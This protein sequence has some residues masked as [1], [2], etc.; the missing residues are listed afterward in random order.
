MQLYWLQMGWSPLV[1]GGK[2]GKGRNGWDGLGV[3]EGWGLWSGQGNTADPSFSTGAGEESPLCAAVWMASRSSTNTPL[4]LWQG[5]LCRAA[6]LLDTPN[7]DPEP[8]FKVNTRC[9]SLD[10]KG[11]YEDARE[12]F[13]A[14]GSFNVAAHHVRTVTT[15]IF[16][17]SQPQTVMS[18]FRHSLE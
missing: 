9:P 4:W 1:F 15:S 2:R 17:V 10:L 12:A 14:F 16:N 6:D 3:Q 18:S 13:T 8:A 7:T 5:L 11:L